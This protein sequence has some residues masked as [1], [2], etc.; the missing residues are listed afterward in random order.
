M[1]YSASIYLHRME[2]L[3]QILILVQIQIQLWLDTSYNIFILE[4]HAF[5]EK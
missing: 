2:F 1:V 4:V 3:E 5:K